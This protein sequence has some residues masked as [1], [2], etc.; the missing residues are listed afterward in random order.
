MRVLMVMFDSLNRNML[1]PYGGTIAK[2][3]NFNKLAAHSVTFEN[4]YA[5]SLPC[6]PARRELH[7]GRYNFL[8]RSWGPLEPF[9]DSMPELL[10]HHGIHSHLATDHYHYFEDGGA[11]Y[12]TRY[13]T[14]EGFRGQEGDAWKG[15]VGEN[16]S[17]EGFRNQCDGYAESWEHN[18]VPQDFINRSY[19]DQEEKQPQCRTFEAGKE[20]IHANQQADQWFLQ[21]E[22]FDPHEPFYTQERFKKLYPHEYK[23]GVYDWPDYRPLDE[24]DTPEDIVHL[25]A[26]YGAL[27]SMCDEKLGEILELLDQYDMWKDT[28]VIV[29]TDHGFLLSEHGQWAK[30]HCPFYNEVA[31]IPLFIWDPAAGIKGRRVTSLVQTIDLPATILYQFGIKL[32]VDMEGKPLQPVIEEDVPVRDAAL[33]GIYGGQV[34]CTDGRYVYMRSPV[35]EETEIF[36]YTLMPTRHGGRRAFI[37]NEELKK[38]TLEKGFPFTKGL[39]VMKIPYERKVGQSSYQT[40]LFDLKKDPFQEN[41]VRDEEVE[42]RMIGLMRKC[43]IENQCPEEI[44]ERYG[45]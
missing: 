8:H 32:P 34:N 9:D 23:G 12:H 1:E 14:W 6:M 36:Q 21:I 43:M 19:L 4:C 22:T 38:M 15:I 25:R 44:L 28:M 45:I 24:R 20:F 27:L 37:H 33:F 40:M 30:C 31:R 2:T 41:P 11:T 7:T 39:P 16:R 10:N 3:P 13:R 18:W 26:E 29:N 5:G 35:N 42:N 17:P